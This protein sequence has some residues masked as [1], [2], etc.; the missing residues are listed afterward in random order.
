MDREIRVFISST[1]RDMQQERDI[2]VKQVLP[3]LRKLCMER[4]V[5][6]TVVDLRWYGL[7]LYSPGPLLTL[8]C[9]GV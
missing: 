4:D 1:F 9:K 7:A 8:H 5:I 3:K 2:L 6:F